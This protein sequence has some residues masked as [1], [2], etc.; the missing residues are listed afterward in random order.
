MPKVKDSA[1]ETQPTSIRLPNHLYEQLELKS[2]EW[3]GI[4]ISKTIQL[5]LQAAMENPPDRDQSK[6]GMMTYTLL[7]EAILSLVEDGDGLI[8]RAYQQFEQIME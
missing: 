7:R 5:L 4:G 6:Y 8:D 2:Q 3:G 1:K